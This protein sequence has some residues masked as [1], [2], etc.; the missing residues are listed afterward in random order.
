MTRLRFVGLAFVLPLLAGTALFAHHLSGYPAPTLSGGAA[1]DDVTLNWSAA[2]FPA[3]CTHAQ[4]Y[5]IFRQDN[6]SGDF[7]QITEV[8][9]LSYTDM[10][11]ANGN[12]AYRVQARCNTAPPGPDVNNL[13]LM[14]NTVNVDITSAPACSGAPEVSASATPLRL[15][16]PNGKMISVTVNG[17]VAAQPHCTTPDTVSYWIVD[18]YGE[19]SSGAVDVSVSSSSF[20]FQVALEASRRGQDLDGREYQI[21]VSTQDGGYAVGS[22]IVPHD[23]RQK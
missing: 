10:D 18:E 20:T 4:N 7:E 12:Y 21:H 1:G 5:R 16:P 8:G 9:T 6:G 17:N 15:W 23:Q 14:S 22:V 3:L 2:A 19:L 13:S 11:L